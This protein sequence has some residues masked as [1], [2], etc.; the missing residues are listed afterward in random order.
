MDIVWT[1]GATES[2][3]MVFHHF[4]ALEGNRARGQ[5]REVWVSAIEHP[6]VVAA[7]DY[8]C[9]GRVHRLPATRGGMVELAWIAER[10]K[11]VRPML[12]A[13]MAANNE[14]GVLQPWREVLALCQSM[15]IPFFCD[16]AQ[17]VGKMPCGG[18]GESDFVSG[19]A[20]KFGG[21]KG[22]GFLKCPTDGSVWPLL[23]GGQQE[24][25]RRAGTANVPGVLAML[26]ALRSRE[27]LLAAQEHQARLRWR[28]Q[29]ERQLLDVLQGSEVVGLE[30]ERLWNTVSALMPPAE[31]EQEHRWVVKLDRFGYAVSTGSACAS[32]QEKSSHVLAAMGYR[33]DEASRVLRFS[34]G[35]ETREQDWAALLS[36]LRK[37]QSLLAV[38]D[39]GAGTGS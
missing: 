24:E 23:S 36:G 9:A 38:G 12:V 26:A 11:Q 27:R 31:C 34:S 4:A 39:N 22:V 30:H 21:P 33:P 6:C 8:Y 5:E 29:F 32:G 10:L 2:S 25:G 15:E 7:A 16:A 35:W 19:C 13:V 14:T 37:V 1:S 20:H 17:W 28:N 3:N 18:L